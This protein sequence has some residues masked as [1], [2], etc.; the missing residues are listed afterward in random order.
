MR[1]SS[2]LITVIF[3]ISLSC[4]KDIDEDSAF[5]NSIKQGNYSEP[6]SVV[7]DFLNDLNY[8]DTRNLGENSNM[9]ILGEWLEQKPCIQDV[10]I[11]CFWCL[12][13]N[14]SFSTL[15]IILDEKSDTMVLTI[16]GIIPNKAVGISKK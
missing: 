4:S 14:P 10:E 12:Y 13:S 7:N 16:K 1:L 2:I 3:L 8:E 9:E 6:L 5:C 15:Y 11:S